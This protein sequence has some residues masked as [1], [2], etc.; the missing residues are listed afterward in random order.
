MHHDVQELTKQLL[1]GDQD[2]AWDIID[3]QIEQ[4]QD[5]LQIYHSLIT[6]AMRRIG[7][8][9]EKD[10]ITVA[11]EH[12]ATTTCD[13]ILTRYHF[14]KKKEFKQTDYPRRK[15]LFLCLEQEQHYIGL[16]MVALL[17][18]E[19]GWETRLL[20]ANLPLEYAEKIAED[21][22]PEVIGLSLTIVY[23][24]ERLEQYVKALESLKHQPTIMVGGRLTSAYD[25]SLYCSTETRIL[26]C[27]EDIEAFL[28][29]T[30]YGV[31]ENA[32]N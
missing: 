10:E 30:G 15:A 12:L 2:A 26:K 11:D 29:E 9:W 3:N 22:E 25:F 24:A 14:V 17:F 13:F 28:Q 1:A 18:E 6:E 31:R 32:R 27:L 21:W 16:K 23:H 4:G 19:Y 7:E 20:G 8:L 5:S